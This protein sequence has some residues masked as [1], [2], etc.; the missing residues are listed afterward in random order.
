MKKTVAFKE[1][2]HTHKRPPK[3]SKKKTEA[4]ERAKKE[5]RKTKPT[6]FKPAG[7][8]RDDATGKEK[9]KKENEMTILVTTGL[10]ALAIGVGVAFAVKEIRSKRAPKS[11]AF[12]HPNCSANGGGEF[13]LWSA[14]S[15]LCTRPQGDLR[16]VVY[17]SDSSSAGPAIIARAARDFGMKASDL[18]GVSFIR[19]KAAHLAFRPFPVAAL[20]LQ[21]FFGAVAAVEALLRFTPEVFIDTTGAAFSLPV[22]RFIGGCSGV[23]AYVHYPTVSTDMIRDVV[24]SAASSS[25]L[26]RKAKVAYYRA[27]AWAYG[28]AI[29]SAHSVMAN[30]SWTASHISSLRPRPPRVNVVFPPCSFSSSPTSSWGQLMEEKSQLPMVIISIGQWRPEKRQADQVRA[31]RRLLLAHPELWGKVKLVLVG[32][33]RGP[34][35]AS[36]REDVRKMCAE[37]GLLAANAV[38]IPDDVDAAEKTRLLRKAVIGL[39]SMRDEHFGICVVEYM[40]AA[41][42]PVAHNSAGPR[43]DI[44]VPSITADTI[45]ADESSTGG[46]AVG[47][48]ATTEEEY[49]ACI[50]TLLTRPDLR[51]AMA[52]RA[53]ARSAQF[54]VE[55]FHENFLKTIE[56]FISW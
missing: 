52:L 10:I 22:F 21:S 6:S 17:S 3:S 19:V 28:V 29:S 27:F 20:A 4:P 34:E 40:A 30:S 12:F 47:M 14:I 38:E 39:H 1:N 7:V 24:A 31:M 32:S 36:R 45:P 5:Q 43:L 26:R 2:E 15:A 23:L 35:D 18:A 44:V 8:C 11:V 37:T 33:V 50:H 55:R 9:G 49:A 48:L 56:P 16:V 41:A 13:V 42:V 51:Q 54:T 53:R 46:D 25:S